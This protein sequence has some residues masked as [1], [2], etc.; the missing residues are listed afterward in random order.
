VKRVPFICG[1]WKMHYG[2]AEALALVDGLRPL[3]GDL[4]GVEVG[5][6]PTYTAL[7]A[8]CERIKGTRIKLAAQNCHFEAQGAYTGEISVGMLKDVGCSAVI[9]GH[10]E[11]RTLFGE[12]DEGCGKK[13][14]AA[15]KAGLLPILCVGETLGERDGNKT[16]EVVTRQLLAGIAEITPEQIATSVVAYEPVWAIGT[17]RTA[18]PTQAQE[19]HAHLRKVLRDKIG[20]GADQ[21]RIQY[22][23]SMKADNAR[24]LLGQPDI[25]GGLI[26]GAALKADSFAAI[27]K[28]AL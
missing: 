14:G 15:I 20:A 13:V 6:A 18:T 11:R 24:D 16:L 8:V 25:D 12:T 5:I 10:S 27:I 23:G 2:I 26:G 17:G 19:V 1:N 28:A 9:I 3:V 4:A 7:H 21:V 22:G